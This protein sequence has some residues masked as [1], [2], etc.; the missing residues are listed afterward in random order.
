MLRLVV[1]IA[2]VC[3]CAAATTSA[4]DYPPRRGRVY[5]PGQSIAEAR[6]CSC[7][8]CIER[9]CCS[10]E[11][12]AEYASEQELGMTLSSCSR[13]VRRVWTVRGTTSCAETAAAECCPG[14]VSD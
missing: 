2:L 8:D 3:S 4:W 9:R 6:I 11:G 14:T 7:D 5:E 10:G 1:L 13:C 12:D